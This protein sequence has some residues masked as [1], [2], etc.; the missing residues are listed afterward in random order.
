MN[1]LKI[2]RDIIDGLALHVETEIQSGRRHVALDRG[3]VSAFLAVSNQPGNQ[4]APVHQKPSVAMS[5]PVILS[6]SE[7]AVCAIPPPVVVEVPRLS[8]LDDIALAVSTC[9]R[10]VLCEGRTNTVPGTGNHVSPEIMFIGEW[11]GAEEDACGK[12]FVGPAGQLLTKMIAAMGYD[13]DEVFIATVVKCR[14]PKDRT[15]EPAEVSACMPWLHNQIQLIKPKCLVAFGDTAL[16]G[17][18]GNA[19][20]DISK[21][22]GIWQKHGAI[23]LMPTFHPA[24]LLRYP[25]AKKNVWD[26]LKA[27]LKFLG[28]TPP[29]PA[30]Q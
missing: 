25:A 15:A 20:A 6:A 14:T 8:S 5:P 16:R 9:T 24:Q 27:V 13:R 28:K 10:C 1:G 23:P 17:L 7:R 21:A 2:P 18:T 30:K 26:D 4:T 19:K 22:H 11:P 12:P 29:P 3:L